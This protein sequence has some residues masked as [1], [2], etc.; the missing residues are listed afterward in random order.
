M[1]RLNDSSF[2]TL[3]RINL[4]KHIC[5]KRTICFKTC[6]QF[7]RIILN[8]ESFVLKNDKNLAAFIWSNQEK[9]AVIFGAKRNGEI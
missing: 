5:H 1:I 8:K 4:V 7:F 3:F 6:Q 9:A 2:F